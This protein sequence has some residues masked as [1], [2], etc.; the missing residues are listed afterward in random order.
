[1]IQTNEL[2]HSGSLFQAAAGSELCLNIC[3]RPA[4]M[5]TGPQTFLADE[6]SRGSMWRHLEVDFCR[7]HAWQAKMSPPNCNMSAC[8]EHEGAADEQNAESNGPPGISRPPSDDHTSSNQEEEEE[9]GSSAASASA[10]KDVPSENESAEVLRHHEAAQLPGTF[11]QA[12]TN[13]Y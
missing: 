1:M 5:D 3:F 11:L 9:V 13:E 2:Q 12:I 8:A 10:L 7:S 6:A 4:W